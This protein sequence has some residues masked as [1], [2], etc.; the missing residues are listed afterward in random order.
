MPT[1][2][3]RLCRPCRL[4]RPV[5]AIGLVALASRRLTAVQK[6]LEERKLTEP[7][8]AE[9][10]RRVR[11]VQIVA[12]RQVDQLMAGQYHSV[13]RGRGME[14][15]EVREYQPGD[16]VR[17][18][19]WNVTARA[20]APFIKRFKEERELTVLFAVDVSASGIFGTTGSTK[21]NLAVEIA[22]ALM[23]SALKNND[24]V[25]L[26]L[27]CDGPIRY[28]PARKGKGN[29]LRLLRELLATRPVSRTTDLRSPLDFLSRILKRKAVVFVLSDFLAELPFRT[30]ATFN[31]RHDAVAVNIV[32]PREL[33]LPE[34]G[35]VTFEDAETGEVFE[36]DA[37]DARV[38]A[39]YAAQADER[40]L[41]L[42]ES[43]RR[44]GVDLLRLSTGEDYR[45]PLHRF[46]SL[47][48][49]RFR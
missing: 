35:I 1:I 20:G 31:R 45:K 13:F 9:L 15:D 42:E 37:G 36:V 16:D 43:C 19:D 48:E 44:A 12:N 34:M 8:V 4:E 49:R 14:F 46:F 30:L 29:V 41:D 25:G 23:F 3:V 10:L 7:T 21:L 32:D 27:F 5:G 18:I 2:P 33:E 17:A 47:R 11:R 40:A 39:A 24:K 22:A 38:R 26:L 6:A 28:F